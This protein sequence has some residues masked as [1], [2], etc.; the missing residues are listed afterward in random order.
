ML[1]A[2]TS[3]RTPIQRRYP[4]SSACAG[5]RR[6]SSRLAAEVGHELVPLALG[7]AADGL[8]G[9]DAALREDAI[10]LHAP[11]LGDR[12]EQV[13]DLGGEQVLRRIQQKCLDLG[14]SG[15]QI[16][17]QTRPPGADLVRALEGLHAL[18]QRTLRSR[19][20]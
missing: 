2:W 16:A 4:A 14:A 8:A 7:E 18:R 3:P 11:V 5:A 1:V 17:L 6:R 20:G 10:H 9:R 19:S 13:E 15:L 12:Q